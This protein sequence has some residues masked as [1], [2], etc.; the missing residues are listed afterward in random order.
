MESTKKESQKEE[1]GEEDTQN[2][3]KQK[4]AE[5][6]MMQAPP[7]TELTDK[8]NESMEMM[9][10][11]AQLLSQTKDSSGTGSGPDPGKPEEAE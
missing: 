11:M 10:R 7:S 5:N 8:Q 3:E 2:R 1:A 4:D 6:T 9:V